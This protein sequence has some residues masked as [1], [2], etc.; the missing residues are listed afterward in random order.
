[1]NHAA[2]IDL[3]AYTVTGG[4]HRAGAETTG[5]LTAE[6]S[7]DSRDRA[8][9]QGYPDV[10]F[11]KGMKEAQRRDGI[12]QIVPPPF[13]AE[14]AAGVDRAIHKEDGKQQLDRDL[15]LL[16]NLTEEETVQLVES[17]RQQQQ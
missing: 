17:C 1:M 7:L 5:E 10:R 6:Y 8:I 15:R 9:L 12:A 13:A 11:P 14:M 3:P 2:A 4:Q 16:Q